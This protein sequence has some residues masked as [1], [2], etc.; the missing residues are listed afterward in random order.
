MMSR[1]VTTAVAREIGA[2][3]LATSGAIAARV[4]RLCAAAVCVAA[5]VM[6]VVGPLLIE[7]LYG[8]QFESAA[9]SLRLFL[10]GVVVYSSASTFASFFLLQLGRPWIVAS[11]NVAMIACQTVACLLLIP[12]LGASGAALASTATYALGASLNTWRFCRVT[13]LP[14]AEVWLVRPSDIRR[15]WAAWPV[16]RVGSP[17]A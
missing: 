16:L 4:I 12:K 15:V 2:Q 17:K 11:I 1:P 13:G 3:D 10:P 5:A 6:F 14:V 8:A 7:L 9:L